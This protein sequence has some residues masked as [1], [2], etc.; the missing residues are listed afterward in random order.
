MG[1]W[2]AQADSGRF[3]PQVDATTLKCKGQLPWWRGV[4]SHVGAGAG[5]EQAA[6]PPADRPVTAAGS[7][8]AAEGGLRP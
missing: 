5:A 3:E 8:G 4:A 7:G 6:R 1:L 2:Q